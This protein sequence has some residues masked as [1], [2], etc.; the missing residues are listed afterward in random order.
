MRMNEQFVYGFLFAV[1]IISLV[2]FSQYGNLFNFLSDKGIPILPS[3]GTAI[4]WKS[5]ICLSLF[6][7]LFFKNLKG[8]FHLRLFNAFWILCLGWAFMDLFWILKAYITG[9]FLFGSHVLTLISAKDL[10]IGVI[11]NCL[12]VSVSFLF[13]HGFFKVSWKSLFGF[14]VVVGYWIFL[15]VSFPYSKYFF[16]TFIFYVMNFLP[17]VFAFKSWSGKSWRNFLFA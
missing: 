1:V 4:N 14:V 8:A 13:I 17:F 15:F 6:F 5:A 10:F 2:L 16:N 11:R 9:N 7:G 12:M 3:F